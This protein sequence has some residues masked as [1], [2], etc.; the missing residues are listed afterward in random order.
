MTNRERT[1]RERKEGIEK[2]EEN[3]QRN[4]INCLI[5]I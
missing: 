3:W 5:T 2:T 1:D 4:M